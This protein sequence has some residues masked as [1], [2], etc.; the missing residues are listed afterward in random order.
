MSLALYIVF[1]LAGLFVVLAMVVVGISRRL[2]AHGREVI[3]AHFTAAQIVR[4]DPVANFFGLESQGPMQL[5][6]NGALVL[7]REALWFSQFMVDRT[8]TVSRSSILEV[9][10]VRSHLGKTVG[11][12]LLHVRFAGPTGEDAVAFFVRDLDGWQA[13][14]RGQQG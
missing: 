5:R 13:D 14:L 12:G 1:G 4:A 9:K 11:R 2:V 3:D 7:T 10:T 6:G 8:L